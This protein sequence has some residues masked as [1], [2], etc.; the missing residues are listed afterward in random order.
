[1]ADLKVEV[2]VDVV[3]R[4]EDMVRSIMD[5]YA[6]HMNFVLSAGKPKIAYKLTQRIAQL[7][8]ESPEMQSL[9]GGKLQQ[10]L[11][12]TDPKEAI[13][14]I[15]GALQHSMV[16]D[17]DLVRYSGDIITDGGYTIMVSR[18]DFQD[19]LSISGGSYNTA[20][21]VNISWLSWLLFSG[22]TPIIFGY[23]IKYDP[24]DPQYTRTGA[25]MVKDPGG[26]WGIPTEFS[27]TRDNNFVIRAL[28]PLENDIQDFISEELRN[29]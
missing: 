14:D 15:V 16:V 12:V 13:S 2:K 1:M 18:S 21:N 5:E 20:N 22:D 7:I 4:P 6:N 8:E 11:G 23:R 17:Y 28:A 27:G 19:V 9:V 3:T 25:L 24:T 29:A 10:E 26:A